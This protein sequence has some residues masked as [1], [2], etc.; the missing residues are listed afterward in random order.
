MCR[1]WLANGVS[2]INMRRKRFPES[3]QKNLLIGAQAAAQDELRKKR[4][5]KS[6]PCSF[7]HGKA[8][9]ADLLELSVTDKKKVTLREM[10]F[11]YFLGPL[12]VLSMTS[13]VASYYLTFYRTYEDVVNQ[14]VFLTVLPLISVIPM[15]LSNIV[16]GIMVGKTRTKQGKARPYILM[17]AP[18]LLISGILVFCIPYF[19]LG[20]RMVWMVVTYNLFAAIANPVYGT[21]HY[22][23][24]SLSTRDLDQRGKL[25][26]VSNIP[27][28][29]GN[30][31]ISSIV[32]PLILGWINSAGS[33]GVMQNRW[34]V[35]MT[36]FAVLAF[37]GC[38]L[39]YFFTRERIT[40]EDMV[41]TDAFAEAGKSA[42]KDKRQTTATSGKVSQPST[43]QQR[44]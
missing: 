34:Q 10:I 39:E 21:S 6:Q 14:R 33:N 19:S 38:I 16:V 13:V 35:V 26:V 27:A 32:M 17:A 30:G 4:Y 1:W 7:R 18:M 40:E 44:E 12:L 22:L 15:A 24:V 2:V 29:A 42:E 23:M 9:Q 11:G 28:V 3:L 36:M 41:E 31:L 8:V 43:L 25:S 20:V 37:V 5:L